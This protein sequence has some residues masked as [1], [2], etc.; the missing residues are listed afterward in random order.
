MANDGQNN[1]NLLVDDQLTQQVLQNER[2]IDK[3]IKTV[4][5]STEA[6]CMVLSIFG[7]VE[8]PNPIRKVVILKIVSREVS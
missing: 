6:C 5:K 3:V 7:L 2:G 1:L 4:H 8:N